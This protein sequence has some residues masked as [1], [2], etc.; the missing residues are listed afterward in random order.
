MKTVDWSQETP[1][2]ISQIL[3]GE[4]RLDI[5][6]S[7]QSDG[8]F[9]ALKTNTTITDLYI[10]FPDDYPMIDEVFRVNKTVKSITFR[11]C[12]FQDLFDYI[13]WSELSATSLTFEDCALGDKI[14]AIQ[15][16]RITELI[17]KSSSVDISS[18]GIAIKKLD[19]ETLV[20]DNLFTLLFSMNDIYDVLHSPLKSL[21]FKH[22]D[23]NP[24][25]ELYEDIMKLRITKLELG[26]CVIED[27]DIFIELFK[28]NVLTDLSLYSMCIS[29]IF[30]SISGQLGHLKSLRLDNCQI[31]DKVAVDIAKLIEEGLETLD[32]SR[33][34]LTESGIK[35][36]AEAVN[37]NRNFRDLDI[38]DNP[39]GVKGMS[40]VKLLLEKSHIRTLILDG[41]SFNLESM[42]YLADGLKK[43]KSLYTLC[44]E[45]RVPDVRYY[46]DYHR[47]SDLTEIKHLVPITKRNLIKQTERLCEFIVTCRSLI[48]LDIT[49]DIK[50]MIFQFL[51][52]HA[53]LPQDKFGDIMIMIERRYVGKIQSNHAVPEWKN[54]YIHY[55]KLKKAIKLVENSDIVVVEDVSDPWL[56]LVDNPS[57]RESV[58]I[59][60]YHHQVE[61]VRAFLETKIKEAKERFEKIKVSCSALEHCAEPEGDE[62]DNESDLGTL[63]DGYQ[64]ESLFLKSPRIIQL[65]PIREEQHGSSEKL[66]VP[67][68]RRPGMKK[69]TSGEIDRHT[70]AA[71]PNVSDVALKK[72]QSLLKNAILEYYRFLEL[73]SNYRVLNEIASHKILKKVSKRLQINTAKIQKVAFDTLQNGEIKELQDRTVAL[74]MQYFESDR[75]KA[76]EIL[77]LR[78]HKVQPWLIYTSGLFTGLSIPTLLYVVSKVEF[79]FTV[80]IYS[81]L[82]IPIF[83]LYLF[84]CC[85]L[86]FQNKKIN[87]ILIFELDPRS[88]MTPIE[89][90]HLASIMLF[91]Y[92]I[93]FY[94]AVENYFNVPVQIYPI[95]LVTLGILVLLLPFKILNYSGRKWVI[96]L[97][98]R[99]LAS[100]Y[101]QVQ[102]R[103]FFV[104][105]LLGSLTYSF[106]AIESVFCLAINYP[107][108]QADN[109]CQ[110]N[111]SLAASIVICFPA[112]CRLVQCFRR[113]YDS[114]KAHP[115]LTNSVKYIL[116]L[117]TIILSLF[118][119]YLSQNIVPEWKHKYINYNELKS[120]IKYIEASTVVTF[121]EDLDHWLPLVEN[122]TPKDDQF[123]K[124][125][126][127]EV[128]KVQLFLQDKAQ[129]ASA[130]LDKIRDSCLAMS[131]YLE[132]GD[133]H[134]S[135]MEETE[136]SVQMV[137][138]TLPRFQRRIVQLSSRE[139][140]NETLLDSEY[141]E[142]QDFKTAISRKSA[143]FKKASSQLKSAILE[144][145]RFLELLS[146]YRVLN[147]MASQKILKKLSKR[148]CLNTERLK[149]MAFSTIKADEIK[150]LLDSTLELYVENFEGNRRKALETL[151]PREL[152][153]QPFD[154]YI[155]GLFT[156]LSIPILLLVITK[157]QYSFTVFIY[158]GLSIPIL[159]L[160]MFSLCLL[161]YQVKKINWILIF[162]L[163]PRCKIRCNLAYMAP[164]EFTKVASVMLFIY[165]VSFFLAV[166]NYFGFPTQIYPITLVG[167]GLLIL[168]APLKILNYSGRKWLVELFVQ[169]F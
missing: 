39:I 24:N 111:K 134:E 58:F 54:K 1:E 116:S 30:G 144:Y 33:N 88:Y 31:D 2:S 13:N 50:Y 113:Y 15:N 165:S 52:S 85:L 169:Q 154:I 139:E 158:A 61:K 3:D 104:C 109:A 147:E 115:H 136:S 129:E 37:T 26:P 47:Y 164:I 131:R 46:D 29:S 23:P 69:R 93:S 90:T 96:E 137:E 32:L 151:K 130:R 125:F 4:T 66:I 123:V 152:R 41:I 110:L 160:Y 6:S 60:K 67:A 62:T 106:T 45:G 48:L 138:T 132:C 19:L 159:F 77:K 133:E 112:Y 121:Q 21:S 145:Y 75:K 14:V 10:S 70:S 82:S 162:E 102:F 44:L 86:I 127:H 99:I 73:L 35:V 34:M 143:K 7:E 22:S 157:I 84:S 122:T 8:L 105:D 118:G 153:V 17:I 25:F 51:Y 124:K 57:P 128:T 146:N 42:T 36:I 103:D 59:S 117:S 135:E 108:I 107:N 100:G 53:I 168:L 155:S 64:E 81:G 72:A 55:S 16:S 40:H 94:L 140:S 156:G 76:L 56:E 150:I 27:K 161:V 5:G 63:D 97:I 148:R 20:L 68:D 89:F 114:R 87:W 80:F 18:L 83:F 166:E 38:T 149:Q 167:L 98:I 141:I 79:T 120:D 12:R 126:H 163:D 65:R 28:D 91:F 119:K 43:N 101:N 9:E 95:S 92:S 142:P 78:E 11:S 49:F 74:Y 71:A